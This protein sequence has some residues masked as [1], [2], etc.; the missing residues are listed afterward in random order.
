[1]TRFAAKLECFTDFGLLCSLSAFSS[2]VDS[3]WAT[4]EWIASQIDW[5]TAN[6]SLHLRIAGLYDCIVVDEK[7]GRCAV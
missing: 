3:S 7:R 5:S 1:V 6:N 2:C 4:V